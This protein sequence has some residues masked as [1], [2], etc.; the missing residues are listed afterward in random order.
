MI[1]FRAIHSN[2]SCSDRATTSKRAYLYFILLNRRLTV[3]LLYLQ[4]A[5]G[6]VQLCILQ[7]LA[8]PV[9]LVLLRVAGGDGRKP[10]RQG[11][12]AVRLPCCDIFACVL[13]FEIFCEL[14]GSVL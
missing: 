9:A 4:A 2:F 7:P 14:N 11:V 3:P 12:T 13:R 8:R 1:V 10:E 5:S 6:R